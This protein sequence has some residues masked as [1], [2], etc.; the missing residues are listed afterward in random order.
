ML[1]AGDSAAAD[2]AVADDEV[3]LLPG[4][5]SDEPIAINSEELEVLPQGGGRRLVFSRNVE[6]QQG[7]ITLYADRLEAIYPEGASQP[8]R[9]FA[10]GHVRVV[11]GDRRGRCEEATYER[12]ANTIVC[13][14]KAQVTQGCDQVR[15]ESIEFD[16]GRKRVRVVGAASVVIQ[17]DDAEGCKVAAEV[18]R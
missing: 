8:D 14:G 7:D 3:S 5:S 16:L 10:S 11:Q 2:V 15:G 13:R 12:A 18:S 1:S 4:A 17:P 6:V 9:L